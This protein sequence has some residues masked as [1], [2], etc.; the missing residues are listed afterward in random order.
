MQV[1]IQPRDGIEPFLEG[2][3]EAEE[4]IEVILYRLDRLEIEQELV[5]A[6]TRGVRVHALV[7][8][9]NKEDL[10]EIRK[11]E[12][13]LVER[14]VIVTRTAED[15]VR[16]HSKM[17]LIDR[18]MLY[19]LTF[20]FTF[21]DIHHSRSFGLITDKPN[22]IAEAVRLFEADVNGQSNRVEA[23]HFVISPVNSRRRLSEFILGA[24]KQLLIYD[25]K[26]TD[27]RM[28][29][30]LET[31]ADAGVEIKVI[32]A[33][34]RMALGVEVRRMPLIRLHAQ[35]IIRDGSEV[36]FGSQSLRKVEL[37]QR[38]EVGLITNN[39][40]AVHSFKVVFEMDWGDIIN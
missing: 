16:Y 29:K 23:E 15:L 30:L 27:S 13:R 22:L 6:A 40:D 38:R 4:S 8:Y 35:A 19:L 36:F 14:G 12:R 7:T 11:L 2:I 28:I 21:L 20:N 26:L 32:G 17:M 9:T 31:R 39:A 24:Q 5:A 1:I 18:R 34:S 37:D 3:R 25:G 33:M 10:K